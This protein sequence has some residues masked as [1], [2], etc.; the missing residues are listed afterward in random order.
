[1]IKQPAYAKSDKI[2]FVIAPIGEE[3]SAIRKRSDQMFTDVIEPAAS[4]LNYKIIRADQILR[5]GTIA[6]QIFEH[7]WAAQLVIADLA[8][9]NPNVLYELGV[10]H[11]AQ[12]PVALIKEKGR[13][14]P[15][16]VQHE[17]AIEV[18]I[19]DPASME[20]AK[21][22]LREY[23]QAMEENPGGINNLFDIFIALQARK[24]SVDEAPFTPDDVLEA[25]LQ[26]PDL[27]H[28]RDEVR[29]KYRAAYSNLIRNGVITRRQLKGLTQSQ[30]VLD[31]LKSLYV[32]ELARPKT[33]PLD[34]MAVSTWGAALFIYG[35]SD[36]VISDIRTSLRQSPEYRTHQPTK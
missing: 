26:M 4:Q 18:D 1:M 33:A 24:T 30:E 17:R 13:R 8:G 21:T 5:P 7:L 19:K 28:D 6:L 11:A 23:I 15:F 10:R 9:N 12:K 25:F 3:G 27:A 14:L 31:M 20:R 32:E 22:E 2:C 29:R 36:E 16:D 35:I 34:S